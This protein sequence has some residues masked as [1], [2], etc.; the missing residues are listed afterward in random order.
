MHRF[1]SKNSALEYQLC[2]PTHWLWTLFVWQ[3][4]DIEFIMGMGLSVAKIN[5]YGN[6]SV[7]WIGE[8]DSADAA[9]IN[10]IEFTV[11]GFV[12]LF[13][14]TIFGLVHYK[15]FY[16]VSLKSDIFSIQPTTCICFAFHSTLKLSQL[17]Y[18]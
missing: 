4:N 3:K 1:Y 17:A 7:L 14:K 13:D 11:W 10:S 8:I 6:Q 18:S 16:L 15:L 5:Y 2:Y 9:H 12:C